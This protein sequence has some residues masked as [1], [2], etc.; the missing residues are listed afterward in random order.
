MRHKTAS[1][2]LRKFSLVFY[3]VWGRLPKIPPVFFRAGFR[4]C[5]LCSSTLDV[6]WLFGVC[7]FGTK[8]FPARSLWLTIDFEEAIPGNGN[9]PHHQHKTARLLHMLLP[10]SPNLPHSLPVPQK[11][12][13]TLTTQASHPVPLEIADT[14]RPTNLLYHTVTSDTSQLP[15]SPPSLQPLTSTSAPDSEDSQLD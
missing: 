14:L 10:P 2:L 12:Q 8:L 7:V 5:F 4:A 6:V 3:D 1:C 13:N 9:S 15:H 11:I